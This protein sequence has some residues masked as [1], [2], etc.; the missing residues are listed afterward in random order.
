MLITDPES[1]VSA[2]DSSQ[3]PAA[4]GLLEHGSGTNSVALD[5]VTKDKK[6]VEGD[7]II[8]AGSPGK[9]L[10]P[11][12]YPRGVLIGTVT[13]VNQNDTDLFKQIEVQPFVDLSAL[14][15]VMVLVPKPTPA[16]KKKP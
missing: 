15:S 11:S 4:L 2:T 1:A 10:L 7:T 3:R 8:T 6:V 9:G 5:R 14:Q 12:V 13:G 16:A